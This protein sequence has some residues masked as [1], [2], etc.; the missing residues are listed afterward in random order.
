MAAPTQKPVKNRRPVRPENQQVSESSTDDVENVDDYD[1][2]KPK[3]K[4]AFWNFF[5][6]FF[7]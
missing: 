4:G 2:E 7:D 6:E 1:E 3:K 5:R